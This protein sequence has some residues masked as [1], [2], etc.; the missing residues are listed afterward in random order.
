MPYKQSRVRRRGK[1][2]GEVC[3]LETTLGPGE[4]PLGAAVAAG[5]QE[6]RWCPSKFKR[7]LSRQQSAIPDAIT[8][9]QPRLGCRQ[10]GV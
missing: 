10:P 9:I 5:T 6:D 8:T 7:E 1:N 4:A 2:R 3:F